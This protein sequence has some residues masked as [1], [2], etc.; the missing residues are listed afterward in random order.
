MSGQPFAL[1]HILAG[2]LA[3]GV[4]TVITP[5]VGRVAGHIGL[6]AYPKRDR[7]HRTPTPLLGGVAIF[8]GSIPVVVLIAEAISAHM[9]DRF[10]ALLIGA[11]L[12]FLLGLIDDLKTLPPYAKL[13]GQIVAACILVASLP[14]ARYLP[15]SVLMVPVMIFWIVGVTNAFN[16]L[17][18][19]DGLSAGIAAI[20]SVTLF[21]FNFVQGDHQTAMLCIVIA[22]A[23]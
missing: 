16:L 18:N 8:A 22:G 14:I 12:I 11:I 17:D 21:A 2:L 13:L 3:L 1:I 23:C 6:V 20:V 4:A 9:L 10:A 7:W 5:V 15:W 19:M